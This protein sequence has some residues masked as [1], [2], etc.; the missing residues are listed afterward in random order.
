MGRY[1]SK[2]IRFQL[3]M[4]SSG[5]LMC[6]NVTIINNVTYLKITKRVSFKGSYYTHIRTHRKREKTELCEKMDMLL[7]LT[8]MTINFKW[9]TLIYTILI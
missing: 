3:Y 9:Y 2:S 5:D 1:W 4:L 7:S 8:V 6:S